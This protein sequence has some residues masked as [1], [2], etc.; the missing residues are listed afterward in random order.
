MIAIPTQDKTTQSELVEQAL[1]RETEFASYKQY[2]DQA[3]QAIDLIERHG[4]GKDP[5]SDPLLAPA[6]KDIFANTISKE[7]IL[8][9][10]PEL[11]RVVI[12]EIEK[13]GG[14]QKMK[15]T[16]IFEGADKARIKVKNAHSRNEVASKRDIADAV[17]A[18]LTDYEV[19]EYVV[20]LETEVRTE[21][22]EGKKSKQ[23]QKIA[24]N[25]DGG[26]DR[27]NQGLKGGKFFYDYEAGSG[28]K[29]AKSMTVVGDDGSRTITF[30]SGKPLK[31]ELSMSKDDRLKFA[32]LDYEIGTVTVLDTTMVEKGRNFANPRHKVAEIKAVDPAK[33]A[34]KYQ[35]T[36]FDG[37]NKLATIDTITSDQDPKTHVTEGAFSTGT[38]PYS[39]SFKMNKDAD[40]QYEFQY[41]I[42]AGEESKTY[43][44][45]LSVGKDGTKTVVLFE[46]EQRKKEVERA[47][48]SPEKEGGEEKG[49]DQQSADTEQELLE[50]VA[51]LARVFAEAESAGFTA[52]SSGNASLPNEKPKNSELTTAPRK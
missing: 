28:H 45:T 26:G 39:V 49:K 33:Q 18:T 19:T 52:S 16:K 36:L 30:A 22:V 41:R 14:I 25:F 10:A 21:T 43:Y 5:F 15:G 44:A 9:A 13:G 27:A 2:I 50:G 24:I 1:A 7:G 47:I 6:S 17:S 51:S 35:A 8:T 11:G 37:N 46:D 42:T 38:P 29:Y 12:D 20:E 31:E 4:A 32:E 3:V 40:V 23:E 48:I 34:G